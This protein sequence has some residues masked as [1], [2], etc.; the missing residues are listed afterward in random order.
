MKDSVRL[1]FQP[2]HAPGFFKLFLITLILLAGS[3]AIFIR[4]GN[5]DQSDFMLIAWEPGQQLL[6]TGSV[7]ANYP[8]PLWTVIVMLPLVVWTPKTAMLLMYICNMLMLAASLVLFILVF[9]WDPSP[10]LLTLSVLLSGFFLPVL[11]SLWLGQLTIFS[12]FILA[13]TVYFYKQEKWGWMGIALGLSFIKPQVMLLL[14]GLL[15]LWVLIKKK[16]AVLIGFGTTMLVLILISFPIISTPMQ[17]IGNGIS[18][19]LDRYIEVTSTI[20]GVTMSLG[21]SW[22]VPLIL[23]IVLI[24]WLGWLWLPFLKGSVSKGHD[25]F[26]FAI[27]I[28]VNL[29]VIPYSWMHNLAMLVL[30]IGCFFTILSRKRKWEK[31]FWFT[32]AFL[33]MYPL[34]YLLYVLI[35]I[36]QVT[37]AYQIIP[38]LIFLPVMVLL[39]NKTLP[40]GI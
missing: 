3:I 39:N 25:I 28:I 36:P 30:P 40:S 6:K 33:C 15:L 11:S 18:S 35:G 32:F 5:L 26:L 7:D 34:M 4:P 13:L 20:W 29:I 21:M 37:Q 38:V 17:L 27:A 22:L 10:I 9:E 23:S 8:Y 31:A 1:L 24:L 19:H 16:W 14:A 2:I 12:L